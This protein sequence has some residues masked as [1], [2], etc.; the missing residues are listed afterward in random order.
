M[1]TL[2]LRMWP[3]EPGDEVRA[4][5]VDPVEPHAEKLAVA[6]ERELAVDDV[7]A[8]V[9]I[10]QECFDARR[11]PLDRLA[12]RFCRDH[13]RAIFRIRHGA[14]A[15][16]AADV[17]R[18]EYQFVFRHFRV[19]RNLL[20]Q[21][22]YALHDDVESIAV[23]RCIVSHE[24]RARLH[25]ARRY[26]RRFDF[27]LGH[28]RGLRERRLDFLRVAGLGFERQIARHVVVQ[29]R[30][31]R[32]ERCFGLHDARQIA[33]LDFDEFGRALRARQRCR[34]R[35]A[36]SPRRRSALCRARAPDAAARVLSS[37][38]GRGSSANAAA[39]CNPRRPRQ[40]R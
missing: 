37:R 11:N 19:R 14:L 35:R 38:C 4:H 2:V 8:A 16:A 15:E 21:R 7:G 1:H 9:R 26:A 24:T 32:G 39:W 25:R 33:V 6:V 18:L 17:A 5:V 34:R 29:L 22:R 3:T 40:R 23:V 36:R 27:E 30:R 13:Q 12:Q 28:M 31:A 10:G 20:A